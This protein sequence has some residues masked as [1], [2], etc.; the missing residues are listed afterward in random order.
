MAWLTLAAGEDRWETRPQRGDFVLRT[1]GRLWLLIWDDQ[2]DPFPV[3]KPEVADWCWETIG[4]Y[5][6]IEH[7][8]SNRYGPAEGDSWRIEF[9]A[10][11]DM[12]V[13]KLRWMGA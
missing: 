13:F 7:A 11:A 5:R 4:A 2:H 8:P 1:E 12:A 3:L 10:D 9:K 6:I